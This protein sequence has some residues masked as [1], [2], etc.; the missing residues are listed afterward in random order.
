ME[1]LLRANRLTGNANSHGFGYSTR[2][3]RLECW[4]HWWRYEWRC[5]WRSTVKPRRC[6]AA[7]ERP[8]ATCRSWG[9]DDRL[10]PLSAIGVRN[11]SFW[12]T[13][14]PARDW[15]LTVRR[16][17]CVRHATDLPAL[18][19]EQTGYGAPVTLRVLGAI[20]R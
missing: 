19:M 11:F 10:R 14:G 17:D 16:R 5:H 9:R 12:H 2:W 4:H 6:G 3:F 20:R 1:R 8:Q 18:P 13:S 7:N 15:A